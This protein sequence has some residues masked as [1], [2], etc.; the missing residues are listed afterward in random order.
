MVVVS[1]ALFVCG[2]VCGWV[3]VR[4][5]VICLDC[6]FVFGVGLLVGLVWFG[7]L[8]C[9]RVVLFA[10]VVLLICGLLGFSVCYVGIV[11]GVLGGFYWW[12]VCCE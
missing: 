8:V 9:E 10:C 5:C 6:W 2:W 11:F 1:V 7:L 3:R 4:C 12:L